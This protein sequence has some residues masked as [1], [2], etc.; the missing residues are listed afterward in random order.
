MLDHQHLLLTDHRPLTTD[1]YFPL[2][3]FPM[4]AESLNCPNCGAAAPANSTSCEFCKS[5]LATV[6]CPSCFGMMFLGSKHCSRC[7]ARSDRQVIT[8]S[9]ASRCPRCSTGMQFVTIGSSQ[10]EECNHCGG[11]W[12]DVDA[13]EK[14]CA[15]REEQSAVL[16][17]ATPA[18]NRE[19][20][21]QSK[22]RYVPC[23]RCGQLM[24]RINF[25]RCSAQA[26]LQP[27]A[28]F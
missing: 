6:A 17:A 21:G 14:I 27:R 20:T 1:H 2:T 15:D 7:G 16:G 10:L 12:V 22:V 25:A 19:V 28:V 13:F 5:R 9:E 24:N 26:R 18:P 11:I 8:A 4:Q 3:P 23:P